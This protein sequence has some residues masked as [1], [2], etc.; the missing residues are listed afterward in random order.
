MGHADLAMT[1]RY[2]HHVPAHDA[3]ARLSA[4]V[5]ATDDPFGAH[6]VPQDAGVEV[7]G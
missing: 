1:M 2:V 5:A 6:S 3:A 4:V 7:G